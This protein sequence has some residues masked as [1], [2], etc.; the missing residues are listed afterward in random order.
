MPLTCLELPL[1]NR[2]FGRSAIPLETSP[3][4]LRCHLPPFVRAREATFRRC[5]KATLSF[6][7]TLPIKGMPCEIL[8]RYDWCDV[9]IAGTAS[10]SSDASWDKLFAKINDTCVGHSGIDTPEA[11]APILFDDATGKVALLLRGT[12]G[13]GKFK[14]RMNVI[15]LYAKKSGKAS[16][17]EY[18]WLGN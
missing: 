7:Q 2:L 13:T 9:S 1:G 15:C 10:A 16:I 18:K 17:A 3:E 4:T 8:R 12:M 14:A 6:T 11:T 5:S